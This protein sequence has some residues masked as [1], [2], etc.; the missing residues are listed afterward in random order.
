[1]SGPAFKPRVTQPWEV[2][3]AMLRSDLTPAGLEA[4]EF[5]WASTLVPLFAEVEDFARESFGPGRP[6]LDAAADLNR[7]I[8]DEFEYKPLVTTVST[9][10][11]EVLATRRGVCQDFAHLMIAAVRSMGLAARYVSGY[12]LTHRPGNSPRLVGADASHAWVSVFLPGYG[13]ADLDPTNG[14]MPGDEHITLAW[15][16]DYSDVSPLRGV[17]LGGGNQSLTVAVDVAQAVQ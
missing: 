8:H 5:T 15:G 17:I 1:V 10:I 6:L 4:M 7:R 14:T 12:L 2:A 9:P 13:W 16:R 3:R 11:R